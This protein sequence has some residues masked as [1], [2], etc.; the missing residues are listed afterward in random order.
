MQILVDDREQ[1]SGIVGCLKNRN[2][3]D[4]AVRRLPVGDYWIEGEV[5]VERKTV[6]DFAAS[7]R[8]HRLFSQARRLRYAGMKPFLIL[9]GATDLKNALVDGKAGRAIQIALTLNFGIGIVRTGDASETADTLIYIARRVLGVQRIF[10][11]SKIRT[12]SP[13]RRKVQI[14]CEVPGLGPKLAKT[15]IENFD[16]I[17]GIAAATDRELAK[18]HGM[19][20]KRIRSLREVL[21]EDASGYGICSDS[22][23]VADC[24]RSQNRFSG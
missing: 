5:I 13:E 10:N 16:S 24:A 17:A 15:L 18:I 3:V 1:G 19:G 7:V 8:D 22:A 14:L 21:N 20:P 9:E 6:V 11:Y 23:T 4:L 2:E 12:R